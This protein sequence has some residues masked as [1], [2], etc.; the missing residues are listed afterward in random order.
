[1][2]C[3][4]RQRNLT[5]TALTT[6]KFAYY[7][8]R[9][10]VNP[11][12]EDYMGCRIEDDDER[13]RKVAYARTMQEWPQGKITPEEAKRI[14]PWSRAARLF[15]VS[16]LVAGVLTTYVRDPETGGI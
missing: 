13:V 9:L 7:S 5:R 8:D 16:H 14:F 11:N 10:L 12:I 3:S 1:M 4:C 6:R 2:S 15:Y